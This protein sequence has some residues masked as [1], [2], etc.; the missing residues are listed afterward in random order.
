MENNKSSISVQSYVKSAELRVV[1]WCLFGKSV[2]SMTEGDALNFFIIYCKQHNSPWA[3]STHQY[4]LCFQFWLLRL[5]E[6]DAVNP[7]S[8]DIN[9][10]RYFFFPFLQLFDALVPWQWI[11]CYHFFFSFFKLNINCSWGYVLNLIL[12]SK[13]SVSCLQCCSGQVFSGISSGILFKCEFVGWCVGRLGKPLP[14]SW[15]CTSSV[16]AG[17]CTSR[18]GS[19]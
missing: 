15:Y 12:H 10:W 1:K 16:T 8:A 13:K 7:A 17:C 4:Q 2:A 6:A 3:T 19:C 9:V 11:T 14:C 5:S 18:L